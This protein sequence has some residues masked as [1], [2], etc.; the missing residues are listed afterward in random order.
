MRRFA[1]LALAPVIALVAVGCGSSSSNKS[2]SSAAAAPAPAPTTAVSPAKGTAVSLGET[3]Y[4]LT[5]PDPRM[6]AGAVVIEARNSG[7]VTHAIE[8]EA[9]GAGGKDARSADIAP[10]R[11]A[12]LVVTLQAGKKYVWYCPIDGHRG[13]GMKGT[14][15]VAGLP[16]SSSASKPQTATGGSNSS[17]GGGSSG[18]SS[19]GSRGAY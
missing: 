7:K 4:K 3:E 15:T 17:S 10:G 11:T 19:G 12:T 13:L 9:G 14:I 8:V 2:T 18:G 16:S 1:V 5:P 6:K